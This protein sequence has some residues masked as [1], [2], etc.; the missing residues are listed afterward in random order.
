MPL[1]DVKLVVDWNNDGDFDDT[2]D[3]ITDDIID[4]SWQRGRDY[5]SQ[6]SGNSTAG[7]LTAK[8]LN[9]D[10]KY[11]PSNASSVLTGN[12]L[13]GRTVKLMAGSGDF[14]YQFPIVFPSE[15]QWVG[16]LEK[17]NPTPASHGLKTCTFTAY[18]VL[19]YL[20]D[21]RPNL[22]TQINQRTDQAIGAILDNVG[23]PANDRNLATGKTTMTR[24][25][26][27]GPKTLDAM[28]IVEETESGFLKEDKNGY[29][30]FEN[31]H[32]RLEAT[33][34]VTS[35]HTFSDASN[36]TSSY[37]LLK[38]E[39]PLST[40]TNHFEASSRTYATAAVAVLW[41][42]PETGADSPSLSAGEVKTFEASYPNTSSPNNALE[43]NAW[44]T[45]ASTTDYTA[46]TAANGSGT[47]RTSSIAVT[48]SKTAERMVMTFTNNHAT[49][50][51]YLTKIQAR[52]TA[53]TSNNPV[54]VRS[55][56]SASATSY[57]ER[58]FAAKSEFFPNS[59]EAQSWADYQNAVYGSPIEILTLGFD[60]T[61]TDG[62]LYAAINL[63]ISDRVTV[64]A[65]ND[66]D[67]GI[68]ADF[69][70]ENIRQHVS[71][72][73]TRWRTTLKL[74]PA[75]GGYSA[76]WVLNTGALGTSTVPA[77]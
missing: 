71:E 22:S 73:S 30:G 39:D 8:L 69:Y 41:T 1:P 40:I 63:D 46:N 29:V 4:I 64:V 28:R 10:G 44:T 25:W 77:Y 34:S 7:K 14:P 16:K 54:K 66:A 3:D 17:I 13:P 61:L 53:V 47:D 24:F 62:T 9:T 21:F 26:V 65:T 75:S 43:V 55:I 38:Q 56:D 6:L 33:R 5:A 27:D 68:S 72:G 76:F 57:G 19:G 50:T 60:A 31:R 20:N 74:S 11:S 67:L 48:N 52:G 18:G 23:W 37:V 12:I 58:K 49:D 35:Q 42:H 45:P 32:T 36:A 15:V 51:V 2:H 59:T 70:V